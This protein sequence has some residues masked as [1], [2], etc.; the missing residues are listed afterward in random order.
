[1]Q[2]FQQTA[3]SRDKAIWLFF[4]NAFAGLLLLHHRCLVV[5][6]CSHHN[7]K[8]AAVLQKQQASEAD[9]VDQSAR[10]KEDVAMD[11]QKR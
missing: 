5:I 4:F 10:T 2:N 3:G 11:L 9:V 6:V 8:K 1:M 7:H